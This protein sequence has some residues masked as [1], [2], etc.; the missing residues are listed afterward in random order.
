M[1]TIHSDTTITNYLG[2]LGASGLNFYNNH[3]S[4]E[5]FALGCLD[6]RHLR[7]SVSLCLCLVSAC[8]VSLC[9][10]FAVIPEI[11]FDLRSNVLNR[12]Q[13][14]NQFGNKEGRCDLR[15]NLLD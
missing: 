7:V 6:L 2:D 11:G 13:F 8:C 14:A 12:F 4:T 1:H 5:P 9:L 15:N 3:L 10:V